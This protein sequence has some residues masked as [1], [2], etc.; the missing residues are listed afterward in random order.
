VL[1]ERERTLRVEVRIGHADM[2]NTGRDAR[3]AV[4]VEGVERLTH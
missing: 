1:G 3:K 4:C 2:G